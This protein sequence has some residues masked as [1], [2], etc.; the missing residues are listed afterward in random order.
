[1]NLAISLFLRSLK[2]KSSESYVSKEK[3]PF[4]FPDFAEK[5]RI[6]TPSGTPRSIK[7]LTVSEITEKV[8]KP[9]LSKRIIRAVRALRMNITRIIPIR[10]KIQKSTGL[11]FKH[12]IAKGFW[13]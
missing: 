2:N 1:M 8:V 4:V 7:P 5:C 12:S 6:L 10:P 13:V 11:L 3:K 9:K